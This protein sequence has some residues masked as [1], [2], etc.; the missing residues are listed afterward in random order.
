MEKV[1]NNIYV[2]PEVKLSLE[3]YNTLVSLAEMKADMIEQ[4][5]LELYR[6]NS[7]CRIE[8]KAL[9]ENHLEDRNYGGDGYETYTFKLDPW[10]IEN[11]EY[12]DTPKPFA[13]TKQM[14]QRIR[15]VAANIAETAFYYRFGNHLEEINNIM[16]YKAKMEKERKKFIVVTICGWAT[17][18]FFLLITMASIFG[19][20]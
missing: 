2:K 16:A 20:G 15:K 4:R 17:A 12:D 18:L 9:F 5:A 7:I 10:Y 8:V 6:E 3:Q 14:A 1:L 19:R 13:I 11:Q